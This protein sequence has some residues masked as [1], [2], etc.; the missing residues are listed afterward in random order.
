[1]DQERMLFCVLQNPMDADEKP[2]H[3]QSPFLTTDDP[4]NIS[5][6]PHA[7]GQ[8]HPSPFP[9]QETTLPVCRST[10]ICY[11]KAQTSEKEENGCS[12]RPS[13]A[14]HS[15]EM[16]W[17]CKKE[18]TKYMAHSLRASRVVN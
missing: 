5:T 11:V 13:H 6:P 3:A 9:N 16:L 10:N 18:K 8:G 1:M 7:S 2:D 17:Q 15:T 12:L 4:Q 14:H